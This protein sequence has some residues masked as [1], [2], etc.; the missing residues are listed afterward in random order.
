[1][2]NFGF[3]LIADDRSKGTLEPYHGHDW[4]RLETRELERLTNRNSAGARVSL[5]FDGDAEEA[6]GDRGQV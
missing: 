1:M 6:S 5:C 2:S 4:G 3:S